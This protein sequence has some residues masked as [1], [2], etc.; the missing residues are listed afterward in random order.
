MLHFPEL[1]P[2]EKDLQDPKVV[3]R[4]DS[5]RIQR[6]QDLTDG[7]FSVKI[8]DYGLA[9]ILEYGEFATTPCGTLEVIA[10]EALAAGSDHRVDVWGLGIIAYMLLT[11]EGMFD[12][13]A[14]M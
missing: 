2:N 4:I 8:I 12:S 9:C 11:R 5:K 6:I 1:E 7:N 13:K 3:R 14:E 10:P